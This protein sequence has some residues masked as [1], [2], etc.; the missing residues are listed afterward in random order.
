M[1][2]SALNSHYAL[3]I[4]PEKDVEG[5]GD[6]GDAIPYHFD[7]LPRFIRISLKFAPARWPLIYFFYSVL[8]GGLGSFLVFTFLTDSVLLAGVLSA[9]WIFAAVPSA[10]IPSYS[11]NPTLLNILLKDMKRARIIADASK[12]SAVAQMGTFN[13]IFLPMATYFCMIPLATTTEWAGENTFIITIIAWC[14]CWLIS[15]VGQVFEYQNFVVPEMSQTWIKRIHVYL[16]EV[17]EILTK[18]GNKME[19]ENEFQSQTFAEKDTIEA[20]SKLHQNAEAW[21]TRMMNMTS[22]YNTSM[23]ASLF[24]IALTNLLA[25]GVQIESKKNWSGIFVISLLTLM[26]II[27]FCYAFLGMAKPSMEWEKATRRI[28]SDPKAQHAIIRLGWES[29]WE[30]WLAGHELNAARA[31]GVK[32]TVDKVRRASG[33]VTSVFSIAMYIILRE[34]F[35]ALLSSEHVGGPPAA[36]SH[37]NNNNNNNNTFL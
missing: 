37:N 10:L 35:R 6:E 9:I 14:A 25:M 2:S 4:S 29:R 20:L 33:V 23:L 31:F 18:F 13:V 15:T 28:L 3:E 19:R 5:S 32:V 8:S 11:S 36:A 22:A 21:A 26:S 16:S 24:C 12:K 30:K 1:A 34:D 27:W 7:D 17:Y